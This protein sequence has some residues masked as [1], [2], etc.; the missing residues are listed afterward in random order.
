MA[1]GQPMF[2]DLA[3]IKALFEVAQLKQPP[4]IVA[5]VAR[6]D[7]SLGRFVTKCLQIDPAERATASE[8]L[9]SSFVSNRK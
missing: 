6:V 3:P 8:L 7:A 4:A 5:K 2:A 1:L 9:Q